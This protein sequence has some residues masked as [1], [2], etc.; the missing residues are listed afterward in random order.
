VYLEARVGRTVQGVSYGRQYR[1]PGVLQAG[2]LGASPINYIIDGQL[3]SPR[4]PI[5]CGGGGGG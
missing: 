1:E 3:L 5:R 4:T 2:S